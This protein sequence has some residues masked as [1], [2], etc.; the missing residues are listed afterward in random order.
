M[1]NPD[2]EDKD[3]MREIIKVHLRILG[4]RTKELNAK[5]LFK[6]NKFLV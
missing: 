3:N 1:Y 6:S 2:K 4:K 5:I